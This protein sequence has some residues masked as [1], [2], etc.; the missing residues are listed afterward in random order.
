MDCKRYDISMRTPIGKKHGF[1]IVNAENGVVTG[2]LEIMDHSEPFHGVID[3]DGNCIISGNIVTL[4]R[5]V[6]YTASGTINDSSVEL[7]VVAAN[8]T[9]TVT[10]EATA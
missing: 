10:G 3:A 5:T 2:E 8:H 9:F 4:M 1:L 6:K 7:K